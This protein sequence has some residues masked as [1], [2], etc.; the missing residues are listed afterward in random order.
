[1][2]ISSTGF[3]NLFTINAASVGNFVRSAEPLVDWVSE[4][5]CYVRDNRF[6]RISG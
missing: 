1:M 2:G 5:M 4:A 3:P 6:T